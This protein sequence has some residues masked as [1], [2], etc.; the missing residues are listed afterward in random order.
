MSYTQEDKLETIFAVIQNLPYFFAIAGGFLTIIGSL[1]VVLVKGFISG[2]NE[3][4]K[5][6]KILVD[7]IG[8]L[9]SEITRLDGESNTHATANQAN[10]NRLKSLAIELK[11]IAIEYRRSTEGLEKEIQKIDK[12]CFANSEIIKRMDK[13]FDSIEDEERE[14]RDRCDRRHEIRTDLGFVDRR[15]K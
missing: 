13:R 14:F 1:L 6:N 11:S 2:F 7:Q 12:Q 8:T 4:K 5:S 15:K 9:K 10:D 3:V